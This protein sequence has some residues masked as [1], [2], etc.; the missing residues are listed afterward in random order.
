MNLTLHL[1]A[2]DIRCLR[3]YLGLWLGLLVL[4]AALIVSYVGLPGHYSPPGASFPSEFREVLL[5]LLAWLVAVLKIC[6]LA[7]LVARLVHKDPTVGDTAFWLS[8]PLSRVRLLACKSLFLLLAVILPSLLV[9]GGLLLICGV[10]PQDTLRSVPQILFL[11]LLAVA[12]PAMLAAVTT[13]LARTSLLGVLVFLGLAALVTLL[14]AWRAI[15]RVLVSDSGFDFATSLAG[16]SLVLLAT[17]L[18]VVAHQYLT[19]RTVGSRVLLFSGVA[20]SSWFLASWSLHTMTRGAVPADDAGIPD[21][22]RIEAGIERHSLTLDRARVVDTR[23]GPPTGGTEA[24]SILLKGTITLDPLPPGVLATP[25]QISARLRSRV[26]ASVFTSFFS[27]RREWEPEPSS[28]LKPPIDQGEAALLARLPRD[29]VWLFRFSESD[30]ERFGGVPLVYSGRVGFLV[31]RSEVASLPL[32]EGARLARGSDHTRI[33]GI[34]MRRGSL[35]VRLS[36]TRHRLRG[37]DETEIRWLLVNRSRGEFLTG[38]SLDS[39]ALSS[40]SLLSGILPMLEARRSTLRLRP[41]ADG[42]ELDAAWI[43]GAEL[44]RLETS[45]LG[46]FSKWVRMEGLVLDQV[47]ALPPAPPLKLDD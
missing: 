36:E 46:R 17:A 14:L 25:V 32:V 16:A 24:G 29:A 26:E 6:L 2:W 15:R 10:T 41:P 22:A 42:V 7:V 12:L 35:T 44:V 40:P 19:R 21:A 23:F 11:T 9:E 47:G 1:V 5:G 13:D 4:Q 28:S 20:L 31:Q 45:D 27:R 34:G 37:D 18:I 38:G 8:R 30:Y 33:L 3:S 39:T 43:E